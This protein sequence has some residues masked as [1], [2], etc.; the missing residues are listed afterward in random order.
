MQIDLIKNSL[1]FHEKS[2]RL[3]SLTPSLSVKVAENQKEQLSCVATEGR[4]LKTKT[5][6][7]KHVK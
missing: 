7:R 1:F 5:S 4:I 2:G 6:K 3:L